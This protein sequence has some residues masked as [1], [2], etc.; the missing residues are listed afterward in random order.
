MG[1]GSRI[2]AVKKG[3][4][5]GESP[6]RL[7]RDQFHHHPRGNRVVGC[8]E[9]VLGELREGTDVALV[10][11]H[12]IKFFP[13]VCAFVRR[14]GLVHPRLEASVDVG[15]ESSTAPMLCDS[16]LGRSVQRVL[17]NAPAS[18]E[19]T[20]AAARTSRPARCSSAAVDRPWQEGLCGSPCPGDLAVPRSA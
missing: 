6:K 18:P 14:G 2:R 7:L 15:Y 16:S 11:N 12:D 9:V 1:F 19:P 17:A 13:I 5:A 20:G 8:S 3:L 4:V 10:A